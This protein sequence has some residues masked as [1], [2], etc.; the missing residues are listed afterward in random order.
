[1]PSLGRWEGGG[2]QSPWKQQ[3]LRDVG[4]DFGLCVC[5]CVSCASIRRVGWAG[6]IE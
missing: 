5:V 1:M 3:L 6:I 2:G 4:Y